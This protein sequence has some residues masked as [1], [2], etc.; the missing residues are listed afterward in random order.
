VGAKVNRLYWVGFETN[1]AVPKKL[2]TVV[3]VD[4]LRQLGIFSDRLGFGPLLSLDGRLPGI[5]RFTKPIDVNCPDA[6]DAWKL[7]ESNN[8]AP[9]P[10]PN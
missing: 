8:W 4:G 10:S 7:F 9:D 2:L 1:I 3:L 6:V 5:I